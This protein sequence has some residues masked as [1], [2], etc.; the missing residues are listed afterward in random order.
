MG[1]RQGRGEAEEDICRRNLQYPKP[2][3]SRSALSTS[4]AAR[5]VMQSSAVTGM[6]G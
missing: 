1:E 5:E 3:A 6:P 4:P 2:A